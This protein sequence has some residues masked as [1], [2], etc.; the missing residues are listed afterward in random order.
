M[1]SGPRHRGCKRTMGPD[2]E[3]PAVQDHLARS[4]PTVRI[5]ARDRWPIAWAAL[6]G[7]FLV[8]ALLKPWQGPATGSSAFDEAA[9]V[10]PAPD[11]S[12]GPDPL[13]GLREH[14]QEPLGWRV[15]SLETWI[16]RP[17]RTWSS[18]E[19]VARSKGPVDPAIPVIRLGPFVDALGYC[20]PWRGAERPPAD[21]RITGWQVAADDESDPTMVRLRVIE[22]DEPTVLGALFGGLDGAAAGPGS[23]VGPVPSAAATSS[24]TGPGTSP[25]PTGWPAGRYVFALRAPD[26]ERWWAVQVSRPDRDLLTEPPPAAPTT[27]PEP[28]AATIDRA[29]P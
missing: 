20:S 26:W 17:V 9:T 19:P 10:A 27:D 14:C 28:A 12:A 4:T 15:Y 29:S 1:I 6:M 13:A 2:R 24:G 16:G 5:V 22:P 25:A 23:T 11:V 21:A 8:G 3:H 7:L 18:V